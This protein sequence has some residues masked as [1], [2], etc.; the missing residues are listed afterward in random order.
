[1]SWISDN[2]GQGPWTFVPQPDK[3]G[4]LNNPRFVT[5]ATDGVTYTED[6]G[7]EPQVWSTSQVKGSAG[8][9]AAH[10]PCGHWHKL[11]LADGPG[12]SRKGVSGTIGYVSQQ[13][14]VGEQQTFTYIGSDG[15]VSDLPEGYTWSV[16][17]GSISVDGV[18]T[19]PATNP[20][21]IYNP[22]IA[23]YHAGVTIATLK[24]AVNADTN[25]GNAVVNR[26][27][28]W[29]EYPVCTPGPPN[30]Y[31]IGCAR[32]YYSCLG[33]RQAGSFSGDCTTYAGLTNDSLNCSY[34][35]A[36]SIYYDCSAGCMTVDSKAPGN[37]DIRTAGQIAA[38][39]CPYLLL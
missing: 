5:P 1:M 17:Y 32:R 36:S 9:Q 31:R 25:A 8:S 29:D 3:W 24:V 10:I 12:Q 37:E 2:K 35:Q 22:T 19:A 26:T 15:V 27:N 20:G 28:G 38:G 18:Y 6:E 7:N 4:Y 11:P 21:C 16:D 13:M 30:T 14:S 33:V 39:C 34:S 23:V